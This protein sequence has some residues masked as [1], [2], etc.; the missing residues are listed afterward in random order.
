MELP[1]ARQA[2]FHREA[3][4]NAAGRAIQLQEDVLHYTSAAQLDKARLSAD[5]LEEGLMNRVTSV[6]F[7]AEDFSAI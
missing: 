3:L 4:E 1:A 7:A 6:R 2:A 5:L